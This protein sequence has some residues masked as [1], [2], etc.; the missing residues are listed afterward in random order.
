MSFRNIACLAALA[1]S[2]S[3]ALGCSAE[4]D[5][6]VD[7]GSGDSQ[8]NLVATFDKSGAI[9]LTKPTRILLVGDS[10]K[11]GELPGA[12]AATRSST[13]TTKSCSS[14]RKT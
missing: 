4:A 10:D 2:T 3:L 1:L 14:R 5:V 13:R 9:D 8:D 11:L 6:P 7:D 12:R